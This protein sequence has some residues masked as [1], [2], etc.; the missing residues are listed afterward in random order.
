MSE[1]G[2]LG[3]VISYEFLKHIRRARLW[4]V[5]GLALLADLAILILIPVLQDGY[6]KDVLSMAMLLTVG[7]SMASLGA[8]F[9]AGDAIAGEFEGRTGFMLFTNP[10]K[11]VTLWTGKYLAGYVAVVLL[12]IFTYIITAV[13]LLIIYGE[14]PS[15]M[16][17]SFGLALLY[18]AAVLS[19]TFFFSSFSKGAMGATIITLVFLWVISSILQ[20][21][22]SLTGNPYWYLISAQGNTISN[23]YGGVESFLGN[24]GGGGGIVSDIAQPSIAQSVLGMVIYIVVGFGL[25]IWRAGRR[26]LA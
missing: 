5:L 21:I 23:V 10:I 2:K 1:L 18:A 22:L 9:F 13:S 6:P 17:E 14:I 24:I 7:P 3:I 12:I 16:L 11:K 15:K 20:T 25:A 19:I 8:V 4:V 26:Q